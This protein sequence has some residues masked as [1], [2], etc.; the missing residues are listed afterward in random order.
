MESVNTLLE[1]KKHKLKL[2]QE[3]IECLEKKDCKHHAFDRIRK[4]LYYK[5]D[6][7]IPHRLGY[8]T[9]DWRKKREEMREEAKQ[10]L[11]NFDKKFNYTHTALYFRFA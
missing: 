4:E 6:N 10:E 8:G 9:V 3:D 2:L 1:E 7:K 5:L 11:E